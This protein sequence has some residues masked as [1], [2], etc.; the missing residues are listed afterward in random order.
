MPIPLHLQVA[1]P[2]RRPGQ[3]GAARG[4]VD[5]EHAL[6]LGDLNYRLSLP[7]GEA[8][9]LLRKGNLSQLAESDELTAMRRTGEL[10]LRNLVFQ[11][12]EGFGWLSTMQGALRPSSWQVMTCEQ[13]Q[14]VAVCIASKCDRLQRMRK[15]PGEPMRLMCRPGFRGL[16]GGPA[17]LPAHLQVCARHDALPR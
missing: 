3:W 7:D 2:G 5:T 8:R 14:Q 9:A 4:I 17:Q 15:Q 12:H 6:W 10:S 1:A 16:E 13:V 11:R